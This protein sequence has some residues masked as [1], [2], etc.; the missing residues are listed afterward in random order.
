[1]TDA[2][3]LIEARRHVA[4]AAYDILGTPEEAEFDDIVRVASETCGMPVSLI[5]LL[6]RD[7]DRQWFKAEVGFGRSET[8]LSQSICAYTVQQDDVFEIEDLTRD[9]RTAGNPLVTGGP[10]ARFYA[11]APLR[12]SDG[13]ALGALCVLDTKPNKLTSAQAFVLRT[14]AHQVVTTLELRRSLRLRKESDRR[15]KA[16]LESAVD[17][18]IVSM[19]LKGMVTSW[20][21]GAERILGWDEAEMCGRP[22]H[23]FFTDEDVASGIPEQEM[24]SAL[25]HGRGTDER[26]HLRKDGGLF[27]ANGEMMPL[28]DEDGRHEGFIK[29]LRDR[30]EQRNAAAKEQA[31][32]AFM[33]GV[34]SSSA[35]CIKVLDPDA[36]LTFMNEGGLAAMEA[37]DFNQVKGCDWTGFWQGQAQADAKA[38]F[39]TAMAGGTG[40]F[41]GPAETLK[42][43]AKWWDVQVTPIRGAD[44]RPERLLVV[45]R[46]VTDQTAPSSA[47]SIA[48]S[49]GAACSR[50]CTKASSAARSYAMERGRRSTAGLWRSTRPSRRSPACRW[51]P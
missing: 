23:V 42:G 6:D 3:E 41:Q 14:L 19:D 1:M 13:V 9:P 46:D 48:S 35:D 51:R 30:T 21:P 39:W 44:G 38:A 34:L 25:L 11:G 32:A 33:R 10:Q 20:S 24:A 18:A 2:G 50:A 47:S 40:H 28:L 7:R 29:V 36:R 8:P 43:T 17:Y 49:A 16:I 26:W 5:S 31:D 27:W 15:N 12:T 45:S 4:L 37:D 22:A